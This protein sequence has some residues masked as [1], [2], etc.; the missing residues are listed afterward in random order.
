MPRSSPVLTA[1]SAASRRAP[2]AKA[3]GCGE[4]KT[5]TSGMPM[6]ACSASPRTVLTSHCSSAVVGCS[7]TRTPMARLAIHLDRASE[8]SEPPNPN[9]AA[10]TSRPS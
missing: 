7:I 8:I 4:S 3:L 2:V 5:P 6:P 9:S 10:M 1:T